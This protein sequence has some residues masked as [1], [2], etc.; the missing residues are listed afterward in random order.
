[1]NIV[2]FLLGIQNSLYFLGTARLH[3]QKII[4]LHKNSKANTRKFLEGNQK[5]YINTA[6]VVKTFVQEKNKLKQKV[7]APS[8]FS[9]YV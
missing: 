8:F 2:V 5:L 6:G 3:Q 1:M 7:I 4:L 9:I